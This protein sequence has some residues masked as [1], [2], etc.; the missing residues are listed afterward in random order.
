MGAI[1][2]HLIQDHGASLAQAKAVLKVWELRPIEQNGEV[3]GELMLQENEVHFALDQ[4]FRKRMGRGKLL[5]K[6]L[7]GLLAEKVFLVTRLFK[8]DKGG[9]TL[10]RFMGFRLTH[11]DARFRYY[12][13]D[14]DTR[15]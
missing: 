12:W 14:K 4:R 8:H 10:V 9:D 7:D 1:L 5:R 3:V 2:D 11:E 13:M 6:V 15:R